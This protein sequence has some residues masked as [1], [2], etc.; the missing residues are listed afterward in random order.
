MALNVKTAGINDVHAELLGQRMATPV[1]CLL[2][3]LAFTESGLAP[4]PS[5]GMT[6]YHRYRKPKYSL[7]IG[8][9]SILF[10]SGICGGPETSGS[11][12]PVTENS[13]GAAARCP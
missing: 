5:L 10:L 11:L 12:L 3:M 1:L 6:T 13:Q 7:F 9:C 2:N 4:P 8:V